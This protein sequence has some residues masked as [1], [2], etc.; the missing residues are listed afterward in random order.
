MLVLSGLHGFMLQ[1]I[2]LF[3]STAV[4]TSTSYLMHHERSVIDNFLE[5]YRM[6]IPS[7]SIEFSTLKQTDQTMYRF[8]TWKQTNAWGE[9]FSRQW[10]VKTSEGRP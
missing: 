10:T 7:L 5:F 2:E 8:A 1:K 9:M 4:R 6:S 3:L